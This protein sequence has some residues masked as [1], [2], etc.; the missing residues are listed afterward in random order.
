MSKKLFSEQLRDEIL[1]LLHSE[2]PEPVSA[3]DLADRLEARGGLKKRLRRMLSAMV[4][5]GDIVRVRGDRYGVGTPLDLVSGRISIARSGDGWVSAPDG[6][7]FV[8]K[9]DIGAALP[10]DVVVVRLSRNGGRSAGRRSGKVIRVESRSARAITG[11]LYSTRNFFYVAPIDPAY[12]RDFYV[13][14]PRGAKVGDR[15]VIKFSDWANKHVNPEAEVLD[16]IGP[17]SEPSLDTEAVMR[18]FG[19]VAGFP[20]EVLREAEASPRHLEHAGRR[21]DLRGKFVFTIDPATARDFD[22]ALSLDFDEKSRYVLGVHIADV[23]HFVRPGTRLDAEARRRGNSVYFPDTVVP[24]LP[25]QLS[26]GLC[27]LR[28]DEDRLAFSVFIV[29]DEHGRHVARRFAK[30]WIRSRLRLTYEQAFEIL[31]G[32][33]PSGIAGL[34]EE[35]ARVIRQIGGLAARLRQARWRNSALDLDI[36]EFEIVMGRHGM[37]ESIRRIVNDES[38][39]LIEECMIAANEAVD[40]ALSEKGLSLLHRVH[41]PPSPEK[42]E[43]LQLELRDMGFKPGD[44]KSRKNL[45]AFLK[46]TAGHP[47]EYDARLAV[48]KSM[49]RALY[50]PEPLGHFGLA[51]RFYAHFTSPIRRYPDLVVHRILAS[52]LAGQPNPYGRRELAA[53]GAACSE[54]E[55]AADEAEKMLIEIKK[56]RYLEQQMKRD[57]DHAYD[58]VVVKVCNYGMFVE[59]TELQVQGL[60]H[61]SALADGFVPFDPRRQTL[62]AGKKIHAKGERLKVAVCRV[63]FENRQVDFV[64]V[65]EEDRGRGKCGGRGT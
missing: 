59:L 58:A 49:K 44:L 9:T 14:D 62:R 6:D 11:T 18:H 7:V 12:K 33:A 22:D 39:Q 41:E 4:A 48:L 37:I 43:A 2:A 60:I 36:P 20:A 65:L 53:L 10:G 26:N 31:R 19:Y 40:T 16:I 29:F 27:S 3:E 56:Y 25:E 34:T 57:P 32:G 55:Q 63:D 47:L 28:P 50:S 38:H 13:P 46:S 5:N 54:T 45:A 61:V 21:E 42:I 15:V 23:S 52:M 64:P 24:M 51:K 17:A 35:A 8:S 1:A 30:T